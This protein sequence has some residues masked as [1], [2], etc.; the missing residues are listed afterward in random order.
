MKKKLLIMTLAC[1]LVFSMSA[2]S[3]EELG[4]LK[5]TLSDLSENLE[6]ESGQEDLQE[7]L[8]ALE[9]LESVLDEMDAENESS[10]EAELGTF[11]FDIPAG[12]VETTE[13]YYAPESGLESSSINYLT[14]PNDGSF[15]Q[16]GGAIMSESIELQLESTYDIDLTINLVEEEFF[17]IDGVEAFKYTVEYDLMDFHFKQ[18]QVIIDDP[19]NFHFVTC[20]IVDNENYQEAFDAFLESLRFE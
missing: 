3:S 9:A 7:A 14:Q 15:Y 2:C 16:V 6:A 1:A 10:A 4:Q 18:T 13:G 11:T 12:F 19:E 5:D 20:T 17:E 8:E